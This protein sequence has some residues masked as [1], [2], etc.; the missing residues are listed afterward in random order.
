MQRLMLLPNNFKVGDDMRQ[1]L[2]LQLKELNKDE[3][4]NH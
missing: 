3:R 2:Q 1:E 4:A